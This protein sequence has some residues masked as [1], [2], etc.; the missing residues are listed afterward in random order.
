MCILWSGLF[1]EVYTTKEYTMS[2]GKILKS[3]VLKQ[4]NQ[5]NLDTNKILG[6]KTGFTANAGLCI[7]VLMEDENHEIII[8]TLGAPSNENKPY[9]ITDALELIEYTEEETGLVKKEAVGS[10][11]KKRIF[12]SVCGEGMGHAIRSSVILEHLTKKH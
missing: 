2:T 1:K 3:T 11:G 5:Y 8:I 10:D 7:S 12:Y 4:G 9:N 6:S